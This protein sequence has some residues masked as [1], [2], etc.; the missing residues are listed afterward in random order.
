MLIW[1]I[2]V[3]KLHIWSGKKQHDISNSSYLLLKIFIFLLSSLPLFNP[4]ENKPVSYMSSLMTCWFFTWVYQMPFSNIGPEFL[5]HLN[6]VIFSMN[7]RGLSYCS[8]EI[9]KKKNNCILSN[10]IRPTCPP[11]KLTIIFTQKF[12]FRNLNEFI[13]SRKVWSLQCELIFYIKSKGRARCAWSS[14][15]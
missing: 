7:S 9:N 5:F 6:K 14:P 4:S 8:V 3:I 2:L 1:E 13:D 15:T 10:N 11:G 12:N